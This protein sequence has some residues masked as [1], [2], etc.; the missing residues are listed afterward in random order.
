M[1]LHGHCVVKRVSSKEAA[2]MTLLCLGGDKN[3]QK[4]TLTLN[5][6][7]VWDKRGS[8][9]MATATTTAIVNKCWNEWIPL[10]DSED[11][12]IRIGKEEDD[13]AGMRAVIGGSQSHLLFITY[14]PKNIDVFDLNTFQYVSRS[15]LPIHEDWIRYHCF[16]STAAHQYQYQYQHQHQQQQKYFNNEM[17]LFCKKT[18]LAID[19]EEHKHTFQFCNLPICETIAPYHHYSYVCVNDVI[20][21]FRAWEGEL[22]SS[23]S[24]IATK[25]VHKFSLA[26]RKWT[27]FS[28]SL[29]LPLTECAGVL[30]AD[31][32]FVHVLGGRDGPNMVLTHVRVSVNQVLDK[33]EVQT[34]LADYNVVKDSDVTKE[35]EGNGYEALTFKTCSNENTVVRMHCFLLFFF[36][37]FLLKKSLWISSTYKKKKKKKWEEQK[38]WMK[39][40]KDKSETDKAEI[41]ANFEQLAQP[42][43]AMWLLT[44]S[45]WQ[46]QLHDGNI[47]DICITIESYIYYRSLDDVIL[48]CTPFTFFLLYRLA[49]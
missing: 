38:K 8:D 7:S 21:F 43:F 46:N 1:K 30:T 25:F 47:P 26:K 34:L 48:L 19:F 42:E 44:N 17:V 23:D 11:K 14:Y 32:T 10:T 29:S 20:L 6:V 13:F 3:E 33:D 40:W 9:T 2:D 31:N 16:V 15:T 5:Y 37:F 12:E 39:W 18:G 22:G 36:F 41:I 28:C 27:Y 4:Y 45:K 49:K 35:K 24:T